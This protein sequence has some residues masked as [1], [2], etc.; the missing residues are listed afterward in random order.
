[1][2]CYLFDSVIVGF[3]ELM[4][5]SD[6]IVIVD[7]VAEVVGVAEVVVEKK[8]VESQVLDLDQDLE[9]VSHWQI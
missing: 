9:L 5:M 3:P 8:E 2:Y 1:M 4:S 6:G 7:S